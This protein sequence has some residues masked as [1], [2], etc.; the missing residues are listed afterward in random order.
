MSRKSIALA[1]ALLAWGVGSIGMLPR[2]FAEDAEKAPPKRLLQLG[3]SR[4]EEAIKKTLE[5][6][7]TNL[8]FIETP[9]KEALTYIGDKHKLDIQYD[10]VALRDAAIDPTAIPVSIKIKDVHLESA[11]KLILSQNNLT[12]IIQDEVL[13]ITTKDKAN[14]TL[15]TE[16][17]DVRDLAPLRDSRQPDFDG[18]IR[19]LTSLVAAQT[20]SEV[21]GPGTIAGF[22]P[23]SLIVSQTQE[24]HQEI[25][26]LL[27]MLRGVAE[28]VKSGKIQDFV[29]NGREG[30]NLRFEKVLLEKKSLE[31]KDQTL[32]DALAQLLKSQPVD[33][34]YDQ[35][36][37]R[38]A[39]VDVTALNV[40]GDFK[41]ITLRS[42]LKLLLSQHNLTYVIQDEVLLIT[43][44]DKANTTL[45]TRVYPVNDLLKVSPNEDPS[46]DEVIVGISSLLEMIKNTIAAQTWAQVGGPGSI[47]AFDKDGYMLIVSQT[48]E[49]HD[50]ISDLLK[51]L[52]T[53][54]KQQLDTAAREQAAPK[55]PETVVLKVYD[56]RV[57]APNAPAMTPQEVMEVV[58]SLTDAKSWSTSD[59]YIRG[60]TGKLIVKQTPTVHRQIEKLLDQLG[61]A[62]PK[63]TTGNQAGPGKFGGGGF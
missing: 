6:D 4:G 63:M 37:L 22:G 27:R 17:Y 1:A 34:A 60:A 15:I 54:H 19:L 57:T 5:G 31:G 3:T 56:L 33:L 62:V 46:S 30:E 23:G 55:T 7:K 51:N 14:T 48:D 32:F 38:D 16:I 53:M 50:E 59:A 35:V 18:L 61:T 13:Q 21:G 52:R 25:A 47:E 42:L 45:R 28:E 41:D 44:K 24:V 8:E 11:L 40:D 43:T 49:V 20:W 29:L 9:L 10:V 2:A 39:A 36:A 26:N 12:Y 58:K